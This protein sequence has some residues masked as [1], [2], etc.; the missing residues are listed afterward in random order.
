MVGVVGCGFGL[1]G[2]FVVRDVGGIG[3][4]LGLGMGC[5]YRKG[6][7]GGRVKGWAHRMVAAS[8][9]SRIFRIEHHGPREPGCWC[10]IGCGREW[11]G[12]WLV[13]R[14]TREIARVE[15]TRMPRIESKVGSRAFPP[16]FL[17]VVLAL[18]IAIG[19]GWSLLLTNSRSF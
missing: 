19:I 15:N 12:W 14:K 17:I 11:K 8:N 6:C 18:T 16:L 13:E 5:G 9:S 3:V 10:G 1:E 7:G 2:G 4:S